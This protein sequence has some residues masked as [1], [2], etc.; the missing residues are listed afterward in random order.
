[1]T[2]SLLAGIYFGIVLAI[3]TGYVGYSWSVGFLAG[4][5]GTVLH[6]LGDIFTYTPIKPLWPFSQRE[7]SLRFFR[8]SN[9]AVNKGMA[10]FGGL[11]FVV[12]L[13]R[14]WGYF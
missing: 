3:I 10:M 12:V 6:L 4:F 13:L 8:S 11:A 9:F 5:G 1:M 14:H 7:V 2:H